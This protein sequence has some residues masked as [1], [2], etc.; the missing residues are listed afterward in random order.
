MGCLFGALNTFLSI[1]WME[2]LAENTGCDWWVK[3]CELSSKIFK[4]EL[5]TSF[6]QCRVFTVSI[7][8]SKLL[9]SSNSLK[10]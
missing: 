6:I 1:D 2:F 7:Q 4:T 10:R 5:K 8:N 9:C 3:M